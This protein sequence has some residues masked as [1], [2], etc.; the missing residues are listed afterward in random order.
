[1]SH[2]APIVRPTAEHLSSLAQNWIGLSARRE[3]RY[4]YRSMRMLRRNTKRAETIRSSA[5]AAAKLTSATVLAFALIGCKWVGYAPAMVSNRS[6][7]YAYITNNGDGTVSQFSRQA[8]GTLIFQRLTRAGAMDGPIGIAVD[9]SN[10]FVY[11]ANE[12]DNRVYEFRI[13]RGTGDLE[14]IGDGSVSDGPA[15]RPQQ[16]AIG[17]HGDF[18]YVTNAGGGKGVAGSISQYAI[19]QRHGA[20]R[21]LGIFRGDGLKQ[22]HGIVVAPSGK[23]VYVSDPAAGTILAFAVAPD[24]TLKLMASTPSMGAKTGQPG[25]IAIAPSGGFVYTVD[26]AAGAAAVFKAGA[27]GKLAFVK[28]YPVGVS[29][30]EPLGMALAGAGAD[31]FLYT[32]NRAVDSVSCLAVKDG[33]LML[34]GQSGTGLGGPTGMAVDPGG[35][36]LYVVNRDAATVAQFAVEALPGGGLF[37]AATIFTE[38][39]ANES[40]HSLYIAMTH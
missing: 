26:G 29:T 33:A 38:D 1:M 7:G 9:A 37:P 13:Q 6:A 15:S 21:P 14:A 30:A 4:C 35:H 25:M 18:V 24:G 36:F 34:I 28:A 10:R 39:P 19:D 40:S 11:V 17:P 32:A 16:I 27:D 12:G 8:D 23:F 31:N 5:A 20:L 3:H 22:P 2:Y